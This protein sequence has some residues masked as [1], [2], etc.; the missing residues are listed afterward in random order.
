MIP[1]SIHQCIWRS[2]SN[3]H[4]LCL[5]VPNAA[6]NI[7]EMILLEMKV[8]AGAEGEQILVSVFYLHTSAFTLSI[9]MDLIL[10]T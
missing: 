4:K 9:N 3:L 1:I 2:F 8:E 6:N 7:H 5:A 10:Q